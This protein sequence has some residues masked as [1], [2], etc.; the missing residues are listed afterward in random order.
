MVASLSK[1]GRG[2]AEGPS[3]GALSRGDAYSCHLDNKKQM[4][5]LG[6]KKE[7]EEEE[8]KS[9]FSQ[10]YST[11]PSTLLGADSRVIFIYPAML[12]ALLS[13]PPPPLCLSLS[14]SVSIDLP[15][16]VSRCW[17]SAG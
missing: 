5:Q 6:K 13:L 4:S 3:R 1:A 7:E 16:P 9:G 2:R 15:V 14:V 17:L 10:P 8:R 12:D 11:W